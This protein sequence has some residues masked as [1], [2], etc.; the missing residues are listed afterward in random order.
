MAVS[1]GFICE[2]APGLA[3]VDH[4]HAAQNPY[5][6]GHAVFMMTHVMP[7]F[8]SQTELMKDCF[9]LPHHCLKSSTQ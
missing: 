3:R 1:L 7:R 5:P 4:R 8:K 2:A 6:D 9:I